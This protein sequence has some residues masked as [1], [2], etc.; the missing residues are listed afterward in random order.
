MSS[1]FWNVRGFNKSNKHSVVSEWIG[2]E[3][4]KFGCLLE[5]RVQE[6]KADRIISSVFR[7]WSAM[8]NYEF[9]RLGRIWVVW[10]SDIRVTPVFKSEQMITCS[11]LVDEGAE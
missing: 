6:K 9:N 10:R 7:G 11:V 1:F 4:L 2:R 3:G 8:S 5:T